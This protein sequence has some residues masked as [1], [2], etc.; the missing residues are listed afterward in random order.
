ME[1]N[2]PEAN[3]VTLEVWGST[4]PEINGCKEE[5]MVALLAGEMW[6]F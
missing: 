2:S 1:Q 4:F 5:K 3:G 6:H